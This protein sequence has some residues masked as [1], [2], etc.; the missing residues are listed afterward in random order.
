MTSRKLIRGYRG[1][2]TDKTEIENQPVRFTI[3]FNP[4]Y[5]YKND[6]SKIIRRSN[7]YLKNFFDVLAQSK[8]PIDFEYDQFKIKIYTWISSQG[9]VKVF[10]PNTT[11]DLS[12]DN[13]SFNFEQSSFVAECNEACDI[14]INDEIL[15]L[16]YKIENST[17]YFLFYPP[18]QRFVP[19]TDVFYPSVNDYYQ[20]RVRL[21]FDEYFPDK[22]YTCEEAIYVINHPKEFTFFEPE[23]PKVYFDNDFTNSPDVELKTQ[24]FNGTTIS[25]PFIHYPIFI[26]SATYVNANQLQTD[27]TDYPLDE[28]KNNPAGIIYKVNGQFYR[29]CTFVR[30]VELIENGQ[31]LLFTLNDQ[32]LTNNAELYVLCV[33]DL[34]NNIICT[35][36]NAQFNLL[37]FIHNELDEPYRGYGAVPAADIFNLRCDSQKLGSMKATNRVRIVTFCPTEIFEAIHRNEPDGQ[38]PRAFADCKLSTINHTYDNTEKEPSDSSTEPFYETQ[39]IWH[40]NR[41]NDNLNDIIKENDNYFV[42][43]LGYYS[44]RED[45]T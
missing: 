23:N 39:I 43:N 30:N 18:I 15:F 21:K 17:E 28:L 20:G 31:Y 44:R 42:T 11:I 10:D 33:Y 24:I 36:N 14:E 4:I 6:G 19:M 22:K 9:Q 2:V 27:K 38:N 13:S 37:E 25:E 3:V 16:F 34:V 45:E 35:I 8:Q 40:Y 1:V 41:K 29:M 32:I 12:I 7:F 26:R 5:I